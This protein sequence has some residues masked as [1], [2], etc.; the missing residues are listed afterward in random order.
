MGLYALGQTM[1]DP[2]YGQM[3]YNSSL[4]HAFRLKLGHEVKQFLVEMNTGT[5]KDIAAHV[6]GLPKV[7][8]ASLVMVSYALLLISILRLR[9]YPMKMK[10]R[11][12]RWQVGKRLTVVL[13]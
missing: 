5:G 6:I 8:P 4:S 10:Q 1:N 13:M 12:M 7:I 11:W 3:S 9:G 2:L